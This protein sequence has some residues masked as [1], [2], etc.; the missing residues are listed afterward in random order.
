MVASLSLSSGRA[1]LLENWQ[2]HEQFGSREWFHVLLHDGKRPRRGCVYWNHRVPSTWKEMWLLRLSEDPS[3]SLSACVA[4]VASASS[5]TD[6]KHDI[7][8]I[9]TSAG[10]PVAKGGEATRQGLPLK[11]RFCGMCSSKQPLTTCLALMVCKIK[12]SRSI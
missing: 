1:W 4:V 2:Q 6:Y 11:L 3:S 9:Y 8:T 12:I 5:S 7:W 10:T